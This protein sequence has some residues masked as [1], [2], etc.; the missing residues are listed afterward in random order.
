MTIKK[1]IIFSG[2]T[3][4]IF[5]IVLEIVFRI[6]F[7]VKY[8]DYNTSVTIQG[9]TIQMG[10]DTLIFRNRP[11]YLDVSK[12]Y[13]F[14]EEG[15]KSAPGDTEMP[16]KKPGDFW[17]FLFGASAMEGMGSNKDGDWL[18]I[19][20][21]EDYSYKYSIAYLLQQ[22]LQERLRDKKVHVF[23]AATS[24]FSVYQSMLQY[25]RLRK[26]YKMDWVI[27][28]D[29]NN[30]PVITDTLRSLRSIIETDWQERPVFKFPLKYIIPLT[31]RSAFVNALKQALFN[32]KNTKRLQNA[33][34]NKYPLREKWLNI[35][36]AKLLYDSAS[37][38][39]VHTVD[40]FFNYVKQFDEK[41][42][43]DRTPHLLFV[44]PHLSMRNPA[45][46]TITEK[47]L[48]SYYTHKKNEPLFQSFMVKSHSKAAQM[49]HTI[50]SLSFMHENNFETFVD[51]CHF[52][53]QA[54]RQLSAYF[55]D[56]IME[57][58]SKKDKQ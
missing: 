26:K 25:E 32:A 19:T 22:K 37:P 34:K 6:I 5:F 33:I 54:I 31:K 43:R 51:Y 45:K 18:D 38:V 29:G 3:I 12:K 56:C 7:F 46:M 52:T 1:K 16:E 4:I 9:N 15:F 36:S 8:G 20:G 53:P 17:V 2:L 55:C 57:E 49:G 11:Y 13:Q 50:R 58:Y 39:F 28:M 44:Q 14:N 47:A 41:L 10:D 35:P 40:T 23:S 21:V 30:E 42:S 27:G 48:F 24:S